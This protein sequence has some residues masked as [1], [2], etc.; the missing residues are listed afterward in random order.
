MTDP[1]DALRQALDGRYVI[2]RVLGRGGMA[3]VYLARD[4]QHD[5]PVALKVLNPELSASLGAERF[6]RE[7]RLAARLQHPH[8]LGVYDSGAT[9]DVCWFT[10]PYV[11]G[12]S[13]RDR[14]QR[15][16]QL[17]VADAVRI[18]REI[19]LA[20]DYAHRHQ[21]IHRDI[22]PDNILLI[23]GQAMLADFGIARAL[24]TSEA[25]I[26]TAGMAVGTPAYMSPE[27]ATGDGT[28]D[29]RTDCY[30]LACVL[31]EMLAGEPPFTGPSPVAIMA[32]AVT[33]NPRPIMQSRP[34]VPPGVARAIEL[35]MAKIQADR[36]ATLGE[37]AQMLDQ[38][39]R[40]TGAMHVPSTVA[41]VAASTTASTGA[42]SATATAVDASAPRARSRAPWLVGALV[43]LMALLGGVWW[44][45]RGS[46]PADTGEQ[47][48]AVLP[49]ENAGRADDEYFADGMTDEVRT[50]LSAIR[51]IRVTAR[52]SSSQ[53][54]KSGKKPHEI[55]AELGVQYILTGTVRWMK[56]GDRSRVRVIPELIEVEHEDT[57][58]SQ[59]YDTVMTDVF[60][61]QNSIATRVAEQL[62][63]A[64]G[65]AGRA[66]AGEAMSG[67]VDAYDAFLK[68]EQVSNGM[69]TNDSPTLVKALEDYDRA[70]ALDPA[71]VR[72][73]A[74]VAR[75]NA[76]IASTGPTKAI[77][78]R[79]RFAAAQVEKLAPGRREALLASAAIKLN[80]DLDYQGAQQDY[81]ALVARNPND[82]EAVSVLVGVD[83][84][85]GK[86]EDAIAHARKAT[87]L[88]PRSINAWR[89]LASAY[90]DTRRYAE[91]L[92][93][94][95]TALA[96]APQNLGIIQGK[97]F[98]YLSLGQLDSVQALVNE[99]LKIVDTNALCVRFALYQETM[100][101]LPPALWPRII[102]FSVADFGGDKGHWGL[103]IGHTWRLLG[104]TAKGRAYGDSALVFFDAQLRD[105]PER[106]Q[107]HELRGRALALAG[108]KAD[109]I[110]E[111]E[112]SLA[113]RETTNDVSLTPYV[114]FQ[115][116]RI[117][118]QSGEYNR[119]L[120][121]LEPLLTSP[122]SDVTPAY[123]RIDP[124]FKPLYGNPRF[125]RL[126]KR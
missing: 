112:K 6:Q 49:F 39:E 84:T 66:K 28:L 103:K 38:G 53:Y 73:W 61:V 2:D 32:R 110:A 76:S 123:L 16:T 10:M 77:V 71:F 75:A 116:A 63:V 122:A 37:F 52:A 121:L 96:L 17:P 120:D 118:I 99:R 109:A 58:W 26:T 101:A 45:K 113:L 124:T 47:R 65:A 106:A 19:A 117:L 51:G 90:H 27:Q 11:E 81:L 89:R 13:L 54:K 36:P 68:G 44:A 100:W 126:A 56:D 93:A 42:M 48:I 23:D 31:Y 86:W 82:A 50:Q 97:A 7:I 24:N 108:R 107:L 40:T 74:A 115:V 102:R 85:L 70:V 62:D 33:E 91:E 9:G 104:D 59:P 94:W 34:T 95:N 12:E 125:D 8:I 111:A 79:A 29:A 114:H 57:K 35:G 92:K 60:A 3:T 25:G 18:T 67:N 87:E 72:A 88:D 119:A 55:G 46:V 64:L 80:I 43:G 78:D 105:F 14:L 21:V 41:P 22:K 98:A 4:L 5:R 30:S 1:L 15:E 20:L 69:A 83:R